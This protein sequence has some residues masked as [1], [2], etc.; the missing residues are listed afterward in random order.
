MP[1]TIEMGPRA[2]DFA[3]QASKW[4]LVQS[5]LRFRHAIAFS[6]IYFFEKR[7]SADIALD[8][9]DPLHVIEWAMRYFFGLAQT[10]QQANAPMD[11]VRKCIREAAQLAALAAPYR[12]AVKQIGPQDGLD[13]I[14]ADAT[15]EELRAELAKRVAQ[16][17][18][19][20]YIDLDALPPPEPGAST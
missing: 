6:Q 19:K 20:G 12:S 18:D 1:L 4:V 8:G 14:S 7:M 5:T 2:V 15:A 17:R 3:F 13:G 11:E 10:G 16:L 9:V